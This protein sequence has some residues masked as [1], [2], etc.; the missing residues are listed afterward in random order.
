MSSVAIISDTIA[1]LP[2]DIIQEYGIGFVSPVLII[3]G[4]PFR[5]RSEITPDRFWEMFKDIKDFSTGA[6]PIEDFNRAFD[7]AAKQSNDIAI[8][9]VSK[10]LSATHEVSLQARELYVKEHPGVNIEVIDSRTAAGAQGFVVLEMARAARAGKSLAEVVQVAQDM[11][12]KVRFVCA[13]ETMK[14]LVKIGR[15]P[16]TAYIGE[17]FQVKPI[18]GMVNNTGLVESVGRARGWTKTMEKMVEMMEQYVE[19]DKP[20]HINV[21]FSNSIEDGELLKK[22]ITDRFKTAELFFTPYSPVMSGAVGPVLAL[23]FYA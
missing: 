20:S 13:L 15:A 17:L 21:H 12:P 9:H 18:I 14:L 1:C 2:E 23:S 8:I 7:E 4:K 6:P 22:M 19:A 10:A 5:D 11:I 16:K 3:N